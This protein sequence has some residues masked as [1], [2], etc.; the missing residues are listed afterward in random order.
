MGTD[1]VARSIDVRVCPSVGEPL[2]TT[3]LDAPLVPDLRSI[4]VNGIRPSGAT[5][6]VPHTQYTQ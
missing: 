1:S 3:D 5:V 6:L 2:G 4:C